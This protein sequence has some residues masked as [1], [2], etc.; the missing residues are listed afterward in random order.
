MPLALLC[1]AALL[2]NAVL[3]QNASPL[4]P[5]TGHVNDYVGVFD[6]GTMTRLETRLRNYR[7]SS[8][9]EIAV[10]VVST[11]GGRDIYDYSLAVARGWGIGASGDYDPA[12]LLLVAIEDRKYFT[13]ISRDLEGELTD[14]LAG[15]LQRQYLVP[16]FRKGNYA[17]GIEDT[18]TAY[19]ETIDRRRA[20]E[21]I[22]TPESPTAANT[23]GA[24][25]LFC[26]FSLLLIIFL[27]IYSSIRGDGGKS[28]D[29]QN[30][31]GGGPG[32]SDLGSVLPWIILGGLSSS[33][34]SSS[35]W[36]SGSSWGG[37]GGGGDFG[38]GGA[39]GSW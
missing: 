20:G 16:E 27:I 29:D 28:D 39:G 35:G 13:Q 32:G 2:P 23:D 4:P 26:C 25:R 24:W 37:F 14:G 8:G 38:G 31:W 10:A 19:I 15:S 36:D 7:E 33:G 12:A 34:S 22:R 11:T 9:I 17:K 6:S 1:T 21:D 5:P 30:R 18:I 3:A